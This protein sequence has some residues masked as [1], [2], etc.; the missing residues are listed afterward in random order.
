VYLMTHVSGG[1]SHTTGKVTP[2][3]FLQ[4]YKYTTG[5]GVVGE[6]FFNN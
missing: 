3:V 1:W 2:S 5:A 4:I 6:L